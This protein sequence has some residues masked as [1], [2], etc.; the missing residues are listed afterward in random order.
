MKTATQQL[1]EGYQPS[2]EIN[3]AKDKALALG[4]NIGGLVLFFLTAAL[5]GILLRLAR[6]ELLTGALTSLNTQSTLL[7]LAAIVGLLFGNLLVHE[8][9]HGLFFWLFTGAMPR[10]ALRLTYAYAAAPAWYIPRGPYQVIGLA[11]LVI[12]G[13]I[14][15]LVMA[16]GP[17]AWVLPAALVIAL[18]TSG[19]VGD[20]LVVAVV[21]RCA[22][23]CMINDRGD[24]VTIY[25]RDALSRDLA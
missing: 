23:N 10:F 24:G 3:L 4:L 7:W 25:E 14:G 12:I 20:M 19:A 21:R 9:I 15:L 17:A 18:N 1:P 6:P 16:G 2:K 8:L 5:L 11:P 13:V 22:P